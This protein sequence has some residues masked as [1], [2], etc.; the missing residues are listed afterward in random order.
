[1]HEENV[2]G[3]SWLIRDKF[4][5]GSEK[6][7]RAANK[8]MRTNPKKCNSEAT[9]KLLQRAWD[10]QD[11]RTPLKENEHRHEFKNTHG[12]RKYFKTKTVAAGMKELNVAL[13]MDHKTG[14][15]DN[16]H[17]PTEQE[18]QDDYLR[19]VDYLL[20]NTERKEATQLQKKLQK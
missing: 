18:L 16:Y 12:L 6:R 14:L 4:P 13:L 7:Q 10:A 17:R 19:G 20:I 3:E 15:S 8:S 5:T 9:K 11:V 2:T 1:M